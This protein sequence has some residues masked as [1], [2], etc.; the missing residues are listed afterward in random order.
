LR[1]VRG[2]PQSNEPGLAR[3]FGFHAVVA[4]ANA[5]QIQGRVSLATEHG[6]APA[7]MPAEHLA[8]WDRLPPDELPGVRV[9]RCDAGRQR[10]KR[11][12][13]QAARKTE[14]ADEDAADVDAMLGRGIRDAQGVEPG[15]LRLD[16]PRLRHEMKRA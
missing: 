13:V 8:L 9:E 7:E 10:R 6:R 12:R 4:R 1:G 16:R 15:E 14:T 3:V 2:D 5:E 11:L